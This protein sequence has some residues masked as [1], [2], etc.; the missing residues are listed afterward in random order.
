[1]YL[2]F[3]FLKCPFYNTLKSCYS[4]LQCQLKCKYTVKPHQNIKH[5]LLKHWVCYFVSHRVVEKSHYINFYWSTVPLGF[6]L[7]P[8]RP[9]DMLQTNP[10]SPQTRLEASETGLCIP[11]SFHLKK[12]KY[13]FVRQN[14]IHT[15]TS[16][17]FCLF[18]IELVLK[19]IFG[20]LFICLGQVFF[21]FFF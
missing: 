3:S 20:L 5:I 21:I 11:H 19:V 18:N 14:C 2:T 8:A 12:K 1:M 6:Y 13:S 9:T 16:L 15:G 10:Q 17:I 7:F 4:F